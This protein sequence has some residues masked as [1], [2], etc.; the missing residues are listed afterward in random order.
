M[1][2]LLGFYRNQ[3]S[4]VREKRFK[5]FQLDSESLVIARM[6]ESRQHG[7]LSQNGLLGWGDVDP[8]DLNQSDYDHQY[9][10]F[11]RT[12]AFGTYSLY[13][14]ASGCAGLRS[15][16]PCTQLSPFAAGNRPAQLPSPGRIAPGDGAGDL[17]CLGAP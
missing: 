14:S 15:S 16:A 9:E 7:I 13:K 17:H 12:G 4:V 6:V 1:C 3:W 5:E 2:S 8:S 11:C 10:S